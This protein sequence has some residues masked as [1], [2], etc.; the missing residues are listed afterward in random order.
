MTLTYGRAFREGLHEEMTQDDTI[1]VM[2][3]D[4][5]HRGGHFLHT[6]GFAEEFG[7][8]RIR[9]T[10]ISESAIVAAGLG[11]AI[12]GLR[13]VVD[14][15]FIDVGLGA[16]DEIVN[17]VAKT[18]YMLGVSV[19][20]VI[21]AS[22]GHARYGPQHNNNVEAWFAH[23]P[24]LLVAV[25]ATPMD[26]KAQIKWCLRADDPV[27]FLMHKR[28]GGVRGAVGDANE[29]LPL[30]VARVARQGG[31]VTIVAYG[32]AVSIAMAA[33]VQ[34]EGD[35]IDAEVVDLRSLVPLDL[36]TVEASVRKTGRALVV[37]EAP[38]FAGFA[39]EI[40]ASIQEA[41]FTHLSAPVV[42]LAGSHVPGAHSPALLEAASPTVDDVARAVNALVG[43]T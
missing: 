32:I 27:M 7:L 14:L 21:R 34:V 33:A 43:R 16:M 22:Y 35:G 20:L 37:S 1:F 11:A 8:G 10:P 13:P 4:L 42:R 18:R 40:S 39:A 6:V 26:A 28:L 31:D 25:P 5:S 9:D 29:R 30:G 15:S 24:G 3:T 19:P 2:G 17:Q 12:N 38:R 36:E 41:A 23:T